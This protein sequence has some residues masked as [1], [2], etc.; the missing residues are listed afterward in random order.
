MLQ[1]KIFN[2]IKDVLESINSDYEIENCVDDKGRSYHFKN[3][4]FYHLALREDQFDAKQ[5]KETLLRC[6]DIRRSPSK[7]FAMGSEQ[8][9]DDLKDYLVM[10]ER[11]EKIKNIL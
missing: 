6:S 5:I 1:G 7:S 11:Q 8:L 2:E 10:K 3:D 9:Y 4:W